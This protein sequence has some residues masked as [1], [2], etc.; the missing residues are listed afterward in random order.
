MTMRGG[1]TACSD[2]PAHDRR[3]TKC[4][5]NEERS[6]ERRDAAFQIVPS[7]SEPCP[8]CYARS[9]AGGSEQATL[10]P[11]LLTEWATDA[12]L[13]LVEQ[14]EELMLAD[15]S[16][17]ETLLAVL[18]SGIA[19]PEN[20]GI[21]IEALCIIVYDGLNSENPLPSAERQHVAQR[22]IAELIERRPAVLEHRTAVMDY[23][24]R[25]V[26]PRLD[27]TT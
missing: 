4:G 21:I 18:D 9:W 27:I 14:D 20:R 23:V 11:E 17:V 16:H 15:D 5:W 12:T 1:C 22:V 26:F 3:C 7:S 2:P 6:L 25:V 10:T 8:N 19:L 13:Y 24:Q